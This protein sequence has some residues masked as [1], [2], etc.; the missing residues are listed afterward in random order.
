MAG[1]TNTFNIV[2]EDGN[3]SND[4]GLKVR[5]SGNLYEVTVNFP[6]HDPKFAPIK[7]FVKG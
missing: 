2:D 7:A 5:K 6:N 4:Y 1:E 3:I